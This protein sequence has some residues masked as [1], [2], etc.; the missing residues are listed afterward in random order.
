MSKLNA[1]NNQ[2]IN[3]SFMK[4]AK[5]AY[6]LMYTQEDVQEL[7]KTEVDFDT[8]TSDIV[9]SLDGIQGLI[10]IKG[11]VLKE[12]EE[13]QSR[14]NDLKERREELEIEL[15]DIK[16]K[17]HHLLQRLVSSH[18]NSLDLGEETQWIEKAVFSE[19]FSFKKR[20]DNLDETS[21]DCSAVVCEH[22][23]ISNFSNVW[24]PVEELE[25][26]SLSRTSKDFC[27]DCMK[28]FLSRK[29]FDSC[30]YMYTCSYS[31][32]NL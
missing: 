30:I 32:F 7:D 17:R 31:N 11:S 12:N 16:A 29:R 8:I 28:D 5:D 9:G 13:I 23:L 2:S 18:G 21:A 10:N 19:W 15:K 14:L 20:I 26:C 3:S 6:M 22:G 1:P 24:I 27:L 25:K 4:C